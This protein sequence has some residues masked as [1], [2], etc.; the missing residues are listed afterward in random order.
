MCATF[1]SRMRTF[2]QRVFR[3]VY[4]RTD[5]ELILDIRRGLLAGYVAGVVYCVNT[6]TSPNKFVHYKQNIGRHFKDTICAT[7]LTTMIGGSM[8]VCV[9]IMP[10]VLS[11]YGAGA[12]VYSIGMYRLSTEP[13]DVQ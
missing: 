6:G 5:D 7:I 11:L 9:P 10:F 8:G 4:E 12:V 13:K 3:R 2:G 1:F